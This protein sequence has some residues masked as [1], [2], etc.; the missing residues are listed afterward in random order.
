MSRDCAHKAAATLE[1]ELP[2]LQ[3]TVHFPLHNLI[4]LEIRFPASS[5]EEEGPGHPNS[6]GGSG[7]DDA[8]DGGDGAGGNDVVTL[9]LGDG[10]ILTSKRVLVDLFRDDDTVDAQGARQ[11]AAA[12]ARQDAAASVGEGYISVVPPWYHLYIG[13]KTV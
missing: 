2:R 8:G 3:R 6:L 5:C 13:S 11:D 7:G 1:D 9:D 10:I 4:S 12:G